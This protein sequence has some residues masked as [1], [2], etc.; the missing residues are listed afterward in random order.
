MLFLVLEIRDLN[1]DL[2]LNLSHVRCNTHLQ[3]AL[4]RI[5]AAI[6][7]VVVL[8]NFLSILVL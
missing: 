3:N 6:R 4:F 5:E 1:L 2:N 8:A 7:V